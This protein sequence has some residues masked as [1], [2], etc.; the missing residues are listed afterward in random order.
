MRLPLPQAC[1]QAGV[2]LNE[3]VGGH[4]ALK[5]QLRNKGVPDWK[6]QT[7]RGRRHGQ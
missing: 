6:I 7:V 4:D 3:V 2:D 1:W 5:E